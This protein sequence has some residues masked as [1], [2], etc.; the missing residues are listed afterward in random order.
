MKNFAN[1]VKQPS[2]KHKILTHCQYESLELLTFCYN[3]RHTEA[4][5]MK[6]YTKVR[7]FSTETRH[8]T[9][10]LTLFG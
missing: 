9:K 7:L 10:K 5:P 1:F 3:H 2:L 6:F 4:Y 8:F